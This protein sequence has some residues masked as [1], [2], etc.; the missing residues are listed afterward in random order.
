MNNNQTGIV[1]MGAEEDGERVQNIV[2]Q[3]VESGNHSFLRVGMPNHGQ[4]CQDNDPSYAESL[5]VTQTILV[6]AISHVHGENSQ[7]ALGQSAE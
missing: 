4:T 6:D 2:I 3:N 5:S 7:G 1:V